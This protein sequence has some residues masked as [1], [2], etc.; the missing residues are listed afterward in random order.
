VDWTKE[1]EDRLQFLEK[2]DVLFKD[3]ALAVSLKQKANVVK[4]NVNE[5]PDEEAADLLHA[6]QQRSN[7]NEGNEGGRTG[8][9]IAQ[10]SK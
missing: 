6:L 3:T 8:A 2:G 5:L 10:S 9:G 4:S 7:D 1:Q